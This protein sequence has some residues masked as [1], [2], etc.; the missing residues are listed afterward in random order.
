MEQYIA[1]NRA[2]F[3][4]RPDLAE[5]TR[6][7]DDPVE[8]KKVLNLL[9]GASGQDEWEK[10]RKDILF[11][12]LLA[13]FSQSTELRSYLL[14]SEDRMLGEASRNQVWGIGMSLADKSRL[15]PKLWKGQNLQGETLME[16]RK[17][18]RESQR[19]Y[20][21]EDNPHQARENQTKDS[22]THLQNRPQ[23]NNNHPNSTTQESDLPTASMSPENPKGQ[24][25]NHA[26][27]I[28][29]QQLEPQSQ[30]V[31]MKD[32]A[33]PAPASQEDPNQSVKPTSASQVDPNQPVNKTD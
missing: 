22:D 17:A 20:N 6:A 13:K 27:S 30:T 8:A 29:N 11:K 23:E 16:V 9:R 31:K 1:Y 24:N 4:N 7:T 15:N 32:P 21:I 10:E 2:Q 14:S 26:Q 18:I 12:G 5:R 19:K 33:N 3:A 25:N 28:S